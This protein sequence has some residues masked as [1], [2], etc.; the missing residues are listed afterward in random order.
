M[1]R[2]TSP[3]R[4]PVTLDVPFTAARSECHRSRSPGNGAVPQVAY[5]LWNARASITVIH[6]DEPQVHLDPVLPVGL[7]DHRVDGLGP[8]V[9]VDE[10]EL[11]EAA[12]PDEHAVGPP[13]REARLGQ[14]RAG[15]LGIEAARL[16]RVRVDGPGEVGVL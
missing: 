10:V 14:E 7:L 11:E 12:L 16:V 4:K 13:R 9:D 15:P 1:S 2:S 5:V 6:A 8:L 3:L